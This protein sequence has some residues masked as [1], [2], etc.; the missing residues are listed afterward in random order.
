MSYVDVA[1]P[2]F[3]GVLLITSPR[4]FTK[5]KGETFDKTRLKLKKIGI[6]LVCVAAGYLIIKIFGR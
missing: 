3:A 4:L 6:V 1:I 5:A 2:L